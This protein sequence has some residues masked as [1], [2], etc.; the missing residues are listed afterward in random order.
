MPV[1]EAGAGVWLRPDK[2]A[3]VPVRVDDEVYEAFRYV[4]EAF[5]WATEIA[6]TV[7]GKPNKG[8]AA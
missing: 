6:P 3:V 7:L 2:W 4:I 5:R 1:I 8:V